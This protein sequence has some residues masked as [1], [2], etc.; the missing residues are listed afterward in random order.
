MR[1]PK[2]V[3]A[4]FCT[5]ALGTFAVAHAEDPMLMPEV[6]AALERA[7]ER[8]DA[9]AIAVGSY[10]GGK[11]AVKGFGRVG[12]D[13]ASPPD[14]DT[15]FEIG[16]ITNSTKLSMHNCTSNV[17]VTER[18]MRSSYTRRASNAHRASNKPRYADQRI[19]C[20]LFMSPF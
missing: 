19:R 8:G 11:T 12:R 4:L 16:S 14:A 1:Q 10:V 9:R 17:T 20:R 18:L 2:R 6:S 13:D 7:V 5:A 3:A 15:L